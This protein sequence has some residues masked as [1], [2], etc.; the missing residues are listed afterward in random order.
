MLEDWLKTLQIYD[1]DFKLMET[2]FTH[3]SYKG[4]GYNVDDYQRLEFL[5]DLKY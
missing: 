2:A 1:I 3:G 5:G 4:L